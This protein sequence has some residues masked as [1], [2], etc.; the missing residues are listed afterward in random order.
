MAYEITFVTAYKSST[1]DSVAPVTVVKLNL[2]Q[3]T[4][5]FYWGHCAMAYGKCTFEAQ[6][7]LLFRG[8]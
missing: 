5:Y 1:N 7:L 4:A 2:L 6:Q 8:L 3:L